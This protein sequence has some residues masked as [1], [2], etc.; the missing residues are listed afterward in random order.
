MSSDQPE[1]NRSRSRRRSLRPS[2]AMIVAIVALSASL[3]GTAWSVTRIGTKQLKRGA[4]TKPKL[5]RNAVTSIKVANRSLLARDFK[6]GQLPV[7]GVSGLEQIATQ[8]DNNSESP[9]NQFAYCPAGKRAIAGG[10]TIS[11]GFT[12]IH[13]NLVSQVGLRDIAVTSTSVFVTVVET[14]AT[15]ANWSVQARAVC[16]NAG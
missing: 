4:V 7:P 1:S 2:P 6:A 16:A 12:G 5:H 11:G 3:G 13:P 10:A 9:K 14:T 15:A 8:S